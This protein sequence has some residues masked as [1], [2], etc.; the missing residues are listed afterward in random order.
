MQRMS[1]SFGGQQAE[2]TNLLWCSTATFSFNVGSLTLSVHDERGKPVPLKP[3]IPKHHLG[4]RFYR[5]SQ[6]SDDLYDAYRNMYLAFES[7][8][9]SQYPKPKGREIDWLRRSLASASNDLS[10][11]NLAPNTASDPVAYILNTV[12]EGARLP[13]FHAKDG[14]TY[15]APVHSLS[16]R[17][18]VVDALTML[19]QIVIRM[20]EKW[21]STR[22]MSGWVNLQIV[23]EHNR[24]LFKDCSFIFNDNPNF[25]LQDDITSETISNGLPFD[26][27]FS[28]HFGPELRHAYFWGASRC[29]PCWQRKAACTVS[30]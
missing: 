14:K 11:S 23:E 19:S 12:Y 17:E 7:L 29:R 22:R 6:A 13:L 2:S 26:A 24:I 8:L 18:A 27:Q 30:C 3:V 1:I 16:D 15:F 9:S 21:F 25:N 10:L 4:F 5:L 28:E 20:A